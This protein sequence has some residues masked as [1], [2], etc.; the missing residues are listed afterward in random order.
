MDFNTSAQ[1]HQLQSHNLFWAALYFVISAGVD[2]GSGSISTTLLLPR[3]SEQ[4]Q[5]NQLATLAK[6]L[7]VND[8]QSPCLASNGISL[9]T[10][11]MV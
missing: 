2:C 1:G 10:D 8:S 6:C 11:N 5:R 4:C 3:V 9:M 7:W